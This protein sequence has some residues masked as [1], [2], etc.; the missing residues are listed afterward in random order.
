[1]TSTAAEALPVCYTAR[2]ARKC[3]LCACTSTDESPLTYGAESMEH[4]EFHG[5]M[6]WRSSEKIRL[7]DGDK[8]RVP[9]G[10]LCLICFNVYRALGSLA[11]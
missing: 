7:D 6:P 10:K 8:V 3:L 11:G 2:K 1:M 5:R 4:M 9:S